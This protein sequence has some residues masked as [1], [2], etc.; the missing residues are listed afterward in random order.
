MLLFG[1]LIPQGGT[2]YNPC[3]YAV[4]SDRGVK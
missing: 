4:V 3:M 1:N 2:W